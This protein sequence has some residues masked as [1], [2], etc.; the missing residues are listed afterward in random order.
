MSPSARP[1]ASGGIRCGGGS[2]RR[3]PVG[4]RSAIT[5]AG[6]GHRREAGPARSCAR[7][8]NAVTSGATGPPAGWTVSRRPGRSEEPNGVATPPRQRAGAARRGSPEEGVL[9]R[10]GQRQSGATRPRRARDVACA[11]W[12]TR[13][14]SRCSPAPCARS[15]PAVE[16]GRVRPAVRTKFQVVALLVREE[17]ARIKAD[18]T[19]TEAQR[20][21]QLK[22]LDGIATILAKTAARDTSL[23]VLLAE[24]A[25][26]SPRRPPTLKREMLRRR[27]HR[28]RARA[29]TAG[30][31]GRHDGLPG[32][33]APGRAAVGGRPA[34][35]QPVPRPRLLRRRPARAPAPAGRLGADRPAAHVVRVRRHGASACMAAARARH[36]RAGAGRPPA[37]AAPGAPRRRRRRR[38]PHVPA[39]RRARP[40]QDRAGAARRAGRRRL[41]AARRRTERRQDQLGPRGRA[42]GRRTTRPP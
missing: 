32:R 37:D 38:P 15:R 19:S 7:R 27:R 9:A 8:C 40:R 17:R 21:E 1:G 36:G 35:G 4:R 13:A 6:S 34:A 31:A 41:P 24:D 22:R 20:A 39:R 30:R 11:T 42:S 10:R 25:R 5:G 16:R 33:R 29:E 14:S 12:T 28:G 3:T 26:R 2:R 23:L 18:T